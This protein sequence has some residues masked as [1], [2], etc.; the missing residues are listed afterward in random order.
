MLQ[1]AS[2]RAMRQIR[3][4]T[5]RAAATATH[6]WTKA[7]Q[8]LLVLAGFGFIDWGVFG[9]ASFWWG[10]IAVG[11]SLLVFEAI[12]T[13]DTAEPDEAQDDEDGDT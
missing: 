7:R 11:L 10:V 3:R 6:A 4:S 2:K 5:P 8:A 13:A 1:K 9:L 12:T